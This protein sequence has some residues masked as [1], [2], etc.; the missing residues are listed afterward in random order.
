MLRY[1][2]CCYEGSFENDVFDGEG[3]LTTEEGV[4]VGGFKNG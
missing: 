1:G 4:Y 2:E 3:K